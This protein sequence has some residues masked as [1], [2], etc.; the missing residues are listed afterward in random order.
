MVEHQSAVVVYP[1]HVYAVLPQQPLGNALAHL[2]LNQFTAGVLSIANV[3][4][5]VSLCGVILFLAVRVID[6]R[7]WSEG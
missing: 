3:F 5:Y 2:L 4:Y 1:R 6:K 7:R